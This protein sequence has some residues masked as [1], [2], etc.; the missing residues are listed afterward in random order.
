M[1]TDNVQI[2]DLVLQVVTMALCA[3]IMTLFGRN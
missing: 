3:G 1:A 2:I